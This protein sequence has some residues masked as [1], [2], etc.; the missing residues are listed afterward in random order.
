[1][2]YFILSKFHQLNQDQNK[3]KQIKEFIEVKNHISENLIE[4]I[5]QYFIKKDPKW[6]QLKNNRT[7]FPTEISLLF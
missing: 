3:L 4:D 1:M 5:Y 6:F 7:H 2:L